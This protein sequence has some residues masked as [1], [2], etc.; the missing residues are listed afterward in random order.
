MVAVLVML[1]LLLDHD[2]ATHDP[3][4]EIVQLLRVFPDAGFNG[5]RSIEIAKRDE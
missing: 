1:V 5:L 4:V 2:A 3:V